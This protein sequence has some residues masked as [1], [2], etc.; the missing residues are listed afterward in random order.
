MA[1]KASAGQSAARE[2]FKKVMAEAKTL[3]A[4]GKYKKYT[5]AV[6]KAWKNHKK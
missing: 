3:Y 4:S 6:S 2:T 1:K 5:D